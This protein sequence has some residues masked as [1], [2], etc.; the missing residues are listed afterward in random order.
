MSFA[1]RRSSNNASELGK[2]K[3]PLPAALH[4]SAAF[5]CQELDL[6]ACDAFPGWVVQVWWSAREARISRKA[7]A[8]IKHDGGYWT[9]IQHYDP[10]VETFAIIPTR[11]QSFDIGF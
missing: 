11:L 7:A 1:S 6:S 5:F 3:H 4:Q 10:S 9:A 2:P 8:S